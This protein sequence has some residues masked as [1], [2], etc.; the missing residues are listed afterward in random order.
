[1]LASTGS[2]DYLAGGP[3]ERGGKSGE[4]HRRPLLPWPLMDTW[5]E[6]RRTDGEL[7]GWLRMRDEHFVAVDMLGR[8]ITEP[9]DY[10]DA[11]EALEERGL[12]FLAEPWLLEHPD[13]TSERVRITEVH[14]ERITVR[15]DDYG[16]A[17]VAGAN[18]RDY[19]LPFPAPT[20]LR[21][22]H[23]ESGATTTKG[24]PA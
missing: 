11:E 24:G 19:V 23:G 6:H 9:L 17:A 3:C 14:P 15:Q 16:V 4:F 12:S 10:L 7:I 1:M 8:E 21:P 13:G 18:V 5:I 22:L 20:R 2:P